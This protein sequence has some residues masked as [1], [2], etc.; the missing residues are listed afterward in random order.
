MVITQTTVFLPLDNTILS[1]RG[2]QAIPKMDNIP[3]KFMAQ[4]VR[5]ELGFLSHNH[6]LKWECKSSMLDSITKICFLTIIAWSLEIV[7]LCQRFKTEGGHPTIIMAGLLLRKV[8]LSIN[9]KIQSQS[10]LHLEMGL[11]K[12]R[13]ELANNNKMDRTRLIK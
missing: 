9:S 7:I 10:C 6:L 13:T 1:Q 3:Q 8:N 5:L 11:S 12:C 2:Q 4:K